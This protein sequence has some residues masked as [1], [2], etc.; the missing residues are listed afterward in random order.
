MTFLWNVRCSRIA[1]LWPKMD[2]HRAIIA[3]GF[4][5]SDFIFLLLGAG[6]FLVCYGFVRLCDRL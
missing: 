5:V 6:G 2:I 4:T 3:G 1:F